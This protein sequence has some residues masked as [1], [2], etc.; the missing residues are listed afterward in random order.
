MP[1]AVQG[2]RTHL[3]AMSRYS[4]SGEFQQRVATDKQRLLPAGP[5]SHESLEEPLMALL[6]FS[7]EYFCDLKPQAK[8]QSVIMEQPREGT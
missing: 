5:P 4:A 3:T 2:N 8:V 7:Q 1:R 6:G